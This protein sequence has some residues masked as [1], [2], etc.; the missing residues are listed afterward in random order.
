VNATETIAATIRRE[1]R[2][3]AGIAEGQEFRCDWDRA[4]AA[5]LAAL[6]LREETKTYSPSRVDKFGRNEW[7]PTVQQRRFVSPWRSDL[8]VPSIEETPK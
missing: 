4:A 5:V 2:L 3:S 1:V 8:A 6:E 7:L